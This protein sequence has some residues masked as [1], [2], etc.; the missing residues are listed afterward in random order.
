MSIG[1]YVARS[2][3]H[4]ISN[5]SI[6]LAGIRFIPTP[7]HSPGHNSVVISTGKGIL[8]LAG[9]AWVSKVRRAS[10]KFS[11]WQVACCCTAFLQFS[12]NSDNSDN[13]KFSTSSFRIK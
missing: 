1:P 13:F 3:L 7:G 8:V 12:D 10:F 4:V 5:N 9:D 2:K 11:P 6:P